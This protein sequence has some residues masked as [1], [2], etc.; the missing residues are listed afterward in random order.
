MGKILL[1]VAIGLTF[2][3]AILGVLNR[4]KL[5]DARSSVTDR[6]TKI[7]EMQKSGM[8]SAAEVKTLKEQVTAL[9]TE[10]QQTASALDTAKTEA[11]KAAEEAQG[12]KTQVGEKE[13]QLTQLKS[14]S[15]AKDQK[16]K[17]LE[18]KPPAPVANDD[19]KKEFDEQKQIAQSA[20][21][22][23]KTTESQ[24][25]VLQEKEQ[26]RLQQ[27]MRDGLEG[28]IQAVNT[29]WNFVV[30]NIGDRNGIINN[31]EM[32]VERRNQLIGRVRIT[33][34]ERSTSV[35]D[36]IANSVPKGISIMPGDKVI[37]KGDSSE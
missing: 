27:R 31:T 25:K 28:S 20:T 10:K 36:I 37:Y 14:D 34:V 19:A 21:D 4:G 26:Y 7:A 5:T 35:A 12:L 11:Q 6:D 2:L 16:I 9:T 13:S 30:L 15:D 8:Q 17:D 22:K 32:L 29:A 33:S 3:S 24:L 18:A 23:L 1:F